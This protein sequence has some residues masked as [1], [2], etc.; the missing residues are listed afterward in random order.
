MK[1]WNFKRLISFVK[2]FFL[3]FNP[4]KNSC[5][6]F[7]TKL[8]IKKQILNKMSKRRLFTGIRR[9]FVKIRNYL[10]FFEP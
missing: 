1:P 3:H 7:C 2:F 4:Y 5:L 8:K 9:L 10:F 6:I